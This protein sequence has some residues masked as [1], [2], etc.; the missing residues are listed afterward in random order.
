MAPNHSSNKS[1]PELLMPP[2][3]PCPSA[4]HNSLLLPT[5]LTNPAAKLY[6]GKKI[7][8]PFRNQESNEETIKFQ[9]YENKSQTKT[10]SLQIIP[11]KPALG[12][13]AVLHLHL[14]LTI[15][16]PRLLTL[17]ELY[18]HTAQCCDVLL[19]K[20]ENNSITRCLFCIWKISW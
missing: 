1:V 14:F 3:V 12:H 9:N 5:T 16:D 13:R 20:Q 18:T 6:N 7:P 15:R 19:L 2:L 10:W 11:S 4:F 17:H 8:C